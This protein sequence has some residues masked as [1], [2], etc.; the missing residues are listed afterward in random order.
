MTRRGKIARL[1]QPIR[2]QINRRLQNG[3]EGKQIA[4]WLNSLPEVRAVLDAEF[5]GQ[6]VKE[7]NLSHWKLG[8]Y[9]DWE[10]QQEALEAVRRFGADAAEISQATGGQLADH[11]ALCLT[12]R[13]AVALQQAPSGGDDPAGELQRLRQLCADLVALRKGDHNAQR[14]RIEREKI[15]LE[16]KKTEAEEAARQREIEALKN[17]KKG[18]VSKEFLEWFAKEFNIL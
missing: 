18:G 4:E 5:D 15:D 10:A 14:L 6:P 12:A 17:P 9:R 3:D 13:I 7:P 8:G 1:P 16:L 2:E 11:L